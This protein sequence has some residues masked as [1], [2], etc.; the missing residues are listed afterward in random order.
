MRRHDHPEQEPDE[1]D[2]NYIER[3][4]NWLSEPDRRRL[5]RGHRESLLAAVKRLKASDE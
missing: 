1:T 2:L 4:L 5:G 3:S